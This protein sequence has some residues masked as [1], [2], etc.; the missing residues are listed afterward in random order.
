MLKYIME[1]FVDKFLVYRAI[2]DICLENFVKM[3]YRCEEINLVLNQKKCHFMVQEEFILRHV[4]SNRGIEVDRVIVEV[5]ERL[6]PPINVK[7]VQSFLGYTRFYRHFIKNFSK[8]AKLFTQLSTKDT[9]L[10]LPLIVFVLVKGS[11]RPCCPSLSSNLG[12]R[13]YHFN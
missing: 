10:R 9:P 12:I 7:G 6:S 3:L 5:I 11:R 1:V 13:L 4:L 8:I 2:F